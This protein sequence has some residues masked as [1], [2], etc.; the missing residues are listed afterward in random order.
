MLTPRE[1]EA[2]RTQALL[3]QVG[4]LLQQRLQVLPASQSM[5]NVLGSNDISGA[6]D[7]NGNWISWWR[8]GDPVGSRPVGP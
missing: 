3:Q 6:Y 8:V 7:E 4:A 2:R 1:I 5:Q